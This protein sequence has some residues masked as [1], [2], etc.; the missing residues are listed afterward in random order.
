[1]KKKP[2]LFNVIDAKRRIEDAT[3]LRKMLLVANTDIKQNSTSNE[4]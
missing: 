1:M 3:C 2:S 4:T